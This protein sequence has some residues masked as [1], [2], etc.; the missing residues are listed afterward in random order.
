MYYIVMDP[1]FQQKN[2]W[3]ISCETALSFPQ[4]RFIYPFAVR[5]N[6]ETGALLKGCPFLLF[7]SSFNFLF[8]EVV[9]P[10]KTSLFYKPSS[11]NNVYLIEIS[12]FFLVEIE[13]LGS[14]RSVWTLLVFDDVL[15]K[16]KPFLIRFY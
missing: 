7:F 8:S 16:A 1:L 9:L 12:W 11:D 5:D 15:T 4:N 10:Q 14:S 2:C 13:M 3:T 6:L